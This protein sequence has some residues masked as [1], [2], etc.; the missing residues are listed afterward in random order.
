MCFVAM[1]FG[2]KAP[3]PGEPEIDFDAVYEVLRS[4]VEAEGLEC[5][6]ADFEAGGGFVHKPMFER[7]IVAEYVVVDLTFANPNVTYELGLRHGASIGATLL[8]GERGFIQAKRLPFDLA[9]FRVLPYSTGAD[10]APNA[11]AALSQELRARLQLARKGQLPSDNPVL[12]VTQLR[13]AAVG[14]EKTDVFL[15]RMQYVTGLGRRAA[16]AIALDDAEQAISRLQ[17]LEQELLAP[18]PDLRELHT[19]LL[20]VYLGYRAKS[21]FERMIELFERMP[22]E[23]RETPVAREQLALAH[24]RL[25]EKA[26]KA[27]DV[28]LTN[29]HRG[30]A[31]AALDA[32]A[33][34][35]WTS[36]T[37]GIR[38]RIH[39]G[40]ASS[41]AAAQQD[42]HAAAELTAAIQAYE[43]GFRADPRDYFPGVNAVTLRILRNDPKDAAALAALL[44]VVRFSAERAPEPQTHD[45]RYWLT[46]TRLELACAAREWEAAREAMLELLAVPGTHKW[47]RE[48]TVGN[49]ERQAE[50]RKDEARTKAELDRLIAQ[51]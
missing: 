22:P 25:A 28:P 16:E 3:A 10:G 2:K 34:D 32:I 17:T 41:D 37:W 9:P 19:G 18:G 42:A 23:L 48:T 33:K 15:Q 36:E 40:K 20:A 6:R 21:A 46:A 38:G 24:N 8:V 45:E 39:K 14:H 49:L 7:L 51:M 1:P 12:Q 29:R 5:V 43:A 11:A 35:R 26:A 47:M 31:H 13:P 4:A 27:K 44:P 30:Q 50:A